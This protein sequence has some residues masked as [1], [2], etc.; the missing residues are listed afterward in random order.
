MKCRFPL[1]TTASVLAAVAQPAVAQQADGETIVVTGSRLQQVEVVEPAVVVGETYIDERNLTNVADALNEQPVIRNSANPGGPQGQFGQGVNFA[2][3]LGIG[4]NRTLTL[5]NGRRVVAGNVPSLSNQGSQGSQVDLNFIPAALVDRIETIVVGGAP[6]YGSD[7]IA[8]TVNVILKDRFTGIE[9]TALTGVTEEGDG[10]RSDLSLTMGTAFA[11]DRGHVTLALDRNRQEGVRYSDRAFLREGYA[12]IANPCSGPVGI[13]CPPGA[14]VGN[15]GRPAGTTAATDG[16]LN[17]AIG[18]N[19]SATDSFPGEII[20]RDVTVPFLTQGGLITAA[21]PTLAGGPPIA[22]LSRGYQFDGSGNV[23]RFDPGIAFPGTSASGG[24]GIRQNDYNQITSDLDRD[25]AYLTGSYDFTPDVTIFVEGSYLHARADS[26]ATQPLANGNLFGGLNGALTFT[27][28]SPFLTQSARATLQGL[29]VQRFQLSRASVD[30][31]DLV[32]QSERDMY[33]GVSGVRGKIDAGGRSLSYEVFGSFGRTDVTDIREDVN[34]QRFVNAVNVTRDASGALVCTATPLVQAAPGL[35]PVADPS[36][37]PLNLLG[38]GR[39]DP[40]A[41]DYVVVRN[42][43][44]SRIE[45]WTV[46]ANIGGSLFDVF[47]NPVGLSLGVEHRDE[48]GR[49]TPS[50]LERTGTGRSAPIAPVSGRYNVD[51]VFGE[52][53]VPLVT[54]ANAVRFV[55]R[56]ELFARGRHVDNTVNGGF[57]SWAAGGLFAPVRDVAFRGNYTRSFR[58]P[59]ITELFLP[60]SNTPT[61]V[62]DLCTTSARAQG[63]VPAIR[64][65]NCLAFLQAFPNATPLNAAGVTVPGLTGGNSA[66]ENEV[67]D[68]FTYGVVLRPR[69]V[70]GLSF[71][72]DYIDINITRP[73]ANLTVAQIAAACFDNADFNAADPANGNRFCSLIGR[74]AAGQGGA[75][76]NG[77][78]RGGQVVVDPAN[79]AV[80]SGFVN[81]RRIDFSGIQASFG[82]RTPLGTARLEADGSLTYVKRRLNDVTGIA[83]AQ[84][85]GMIG[86]PEFQGQLNLRYLR[87]AFG[88]ATSINYVGEQLFSRLNRTA[89]AREIDQ[90]AD[91]ATVNL[92]TYI[93]ASDAF[94]LTLAVTNLFDRNGE[95]YLGAVIP[96]TYASNAVGTDLLGRRYSVSARARF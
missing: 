83:P 45:Q 78:D 52:V 57:L 22:S 34:A 56:L 54:R 63:P 42:L 2:N 19:D 17:P 41:R 64:T 35:T 95:R 76:A 72:V 44:R 74:Y 77:G 11:G 46:G 84:S 65:A 93:Q 36:C 8:G 92:S 73:I 75:A 51:E 39:I 62:P 7:A 89:D 91:F 21:F 18:F 5:V 49:F 32:G 68:S 61:A 24:D 69:I 96:A 58:A 31:A 88:L 48:R 87:S 80:R 47:G 9:A 71:A 10:F 81:G 43:T 94:R 30:L 26:L 28:D 66:L 3:V 86:D 70:P 40:A 29:G 37:R 38:E 33:R 14:F 53:A 67:A 85:E 4:S 15:L 20:V 27:V 13:N 79:P 59:S 82:Y 90:L 60:T 55:D 50:E 6:V 12:S 1:L 23:V 25:I 16:R